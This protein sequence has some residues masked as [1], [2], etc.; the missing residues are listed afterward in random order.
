[1]GT[2]A[3]SML[4][5]SLKGELKGWACLGIW[6]K[7]RFQ[8]QH[9]RFNNVFERELLWNVWGTDGNIA[10]CALKTKVC[11]CLPAWFTSKLLC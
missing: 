8:V 2:Q 10:K 6:T 5:G 11:P 7:D 3:Q 9:I 1:L 4:S